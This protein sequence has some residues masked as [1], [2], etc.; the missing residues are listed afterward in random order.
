MS[1]SLRLCHPF[2]FKWYFEYIDNRFTGLFSPFATDLLKSLTRASNIT[3]LIRSEDDR[4]GERISGS[5]ESYSGC[6]GLLQ[7]NQSDAMMYLTDYPHSA[8][9][10][11][12]GLVMTDE[13]IEMITTYRPS[14]HRMDLAQIE[15]SF[16]SFHP[17]V[18][19]LCSI[20]MVCSMFILVAKELL[21]N[22]VG[23]M[24]GVKSP[25]RLHHRRLLFEVITHMTNHGKLSIT[26]GFVRKIIFLVL[27]CFSLVV[28]L[29]L[30]LSIKTDLVVIT[31]PKTVH[32]YEQLVSNQAGVCFFAGSD[33]YRS[34][35]FA[36]KRTLER[37]LWDFSVSKYSLNRVLFSYG[38]SIDARPLI[39]LV[40][41][42]V[43]GKMA[44]IV[45]SDSGPFFMRIYCSI[46]LSSEIMDVSIAGEQ[47]LPITSRDKNAR[48]SL[49]G[50][51]SNA[52]ATAPLKR[53]EKTLRKILEAGVPDFFTTFTA[54]NIN[55]VAFVAGKGNA[56]FGNMEQCMSNILFMPDVSYDK[57]QVGNF[58]DFIV[59]ASH[60]VSFELLVLLVEVFIGRQCS[61]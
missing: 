36:P 45:T 14:T 33:H 18:W 31:P 43:S 27:S 54:R 61:W 39:Y 44:F 8:T 42:G 50:F 59:F 48:I 34:F 32:S 52:I 15:R 21:N 51:I 29:Y 38:D 10:V 60:L 7:T 53:L 2:N 5:S 22:W 3:L 35:K 46:L 4:P 30:S 11:S 55:P 40:N 26:G 56:T 20:T 58:A 12:Q 16:N 41:L 19:I 6:I 57:L 9:N 49:K 13:V 28:I 23:Q 25:A 47:V 1:N 17:E 24:I 37:R